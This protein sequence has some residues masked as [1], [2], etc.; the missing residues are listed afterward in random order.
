MDVKT[1]EIEMD[2]LGKIL[3]ED[4]SETRRKAIVTRME[5]IHSLIQYLKK[6]GGVTK[7]I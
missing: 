7:K 1:L 6:Y 3:D 5:K 2:E 4:I